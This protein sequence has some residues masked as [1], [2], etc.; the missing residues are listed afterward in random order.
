MYYFI[1]QMGRNTYIILIV[2]NIYYYYMIFLSY[3]LFYLDY[4]SNSYS[5][6]IINM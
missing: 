1:N 2:D 5:I 4:S 3:M 6:S